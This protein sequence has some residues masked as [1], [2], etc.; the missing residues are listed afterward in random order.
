MEKSLDS[1]FSEIFGTDCNKPEE[2]S[3]LSLAYIGDSVF[4]LIV[5]T[6]LVE[7]NNM[8]SYKYHKEAINIVNAG[9]QAEYM[10]VLIPQLTEK[11]LEVYKRG[12]NTK[13]HSTAKNASVGCYRKATGFEALIGYLY[14]NK[15]Y[16]RLFSLIKICLDLKTEEP[17]Q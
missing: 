6:M 7:K 5:K 12:R 16:D 17:E 11:E 1:Y 14:L 15:E 10:D 4:D 13:T 9:S 8:Q 3:P 2:Y